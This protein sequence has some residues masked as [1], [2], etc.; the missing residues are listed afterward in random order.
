MYCPDGC[1]V[2]FE[3]GGISISGIGLIGETI[4]MCY[5]LSSCNIKNIVE[6][7]ASDLSLVTD[8]IRNCRCFVS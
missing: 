5:Q 6:M 8:K 4:L 3:A 2:I 7:R 1:L